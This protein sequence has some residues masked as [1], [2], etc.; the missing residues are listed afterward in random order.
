MTDHTALGTINT[1]NLDA[2]NLRV[3]YTSGSNKASIKLDGEPAGDFNIILPSSSATLA[4]TTDEIELSNVDIQNATSE[5]TPSDSDII[6]V[7]SNSNGANRGMTLSNLKNLAGIG[8]PSASSD[9]MLQHNGSSFAAVSISG[10]VTASGGNFTIANNAVDLNKCDFGPTTVGTAES[11]KV[12]VTDSSNNIASINNVGAA[13]MNASTQ[14]QCPVF[15][16]SGSADSNRWR[17]KVNAS[18]QLVLEFSSD[19][20]SSYSVKHIFSSA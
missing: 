17:I 4:T 11:S 8:L 20:G 10:D 16:V 19:S 5:S 13:N 3:Y 15:E 1:Q 2:N 12:L 18:N 7:Y 6:P 9:Q 14:V